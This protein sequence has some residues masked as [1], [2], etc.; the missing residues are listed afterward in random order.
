MCL[1]LSKQVPELGLE[2]SSLS[3]KPTVNP[4]FSSRT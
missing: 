1:S 3:P 4:T 2:P